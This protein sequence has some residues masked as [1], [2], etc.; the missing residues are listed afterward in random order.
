MPVNA[1]AKTKW[2][3]DWEGK[4]GERGGRRKE[5][6]DG[7][8]AEGEN[9]QQLVDEEPIVLKSPSPIFP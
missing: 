3:R 9:K 7:R 1:M 4:E 5:E 6:V 8:K 2:G